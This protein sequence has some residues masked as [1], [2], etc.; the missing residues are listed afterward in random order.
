MTESPQDPIAWLALAALPGL[1]GNRIRQLV[2]HFGSAR[3]ALQARPHGWEGLVDRGTLRRAGATP[4]DGQAAQAQWDKLNRCNGHLIPINTPAFPVLL[5]QTPAPPAHL[6]ALG[7]P[8]LDQPCIGIVGS[9]KSSDYG[10]QV[11]RDLAYQLG[12][13]GFCI[14]SGMALGIDTAAHHGALA[15]GAQTLAVLGCGAD[16]VYPRDNARLYKQIQQQGAILSEFPLGAAPEKG[17]FPRRNRLISGLSLGVV[18]IEAPARSG[19]LITA[20]Y[21]L[22]QNREVFAVPGDIR[23]GASAG[24]HQ[25]IK[26]GA[27]LVENVDDVLEELHHWQPRAQPSPPEPPPPPE[28]PTA[29]RLLLDQLGPQPLP[30][31]QLG[32]DADMPPGDLLNELLQLELAGLIEQHPGRQFTRRIPLKTN[33]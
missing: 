21:A 5:A 27:K 8:Q 17:W 23:T 32:Q 9:R 16:I 33:S 14:V 6:F 10:R 22:E 31:E 3:A 26:D 18:V 15:A 19:A 24:C 13:A 29:Q 4:L 2:E 25:L 30:L 1:S 28:L 7:Q 20:R 11:A 12:R